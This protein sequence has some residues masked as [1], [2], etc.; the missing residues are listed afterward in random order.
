MGRH[1]ATGR[2]VG[3][4]LLLAVVGLLVGTRVGVLA[5]GQFAALAHP[6]DLGPSGLSL[7]ALAV[8]V[9]VSTNL[10]GLAG[11]ALG[12]LLVLLRR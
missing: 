6:V 8:S 9:R 10:V 2:N 12:A 4:G 3:W 7:G 5:H 1:A 11:A